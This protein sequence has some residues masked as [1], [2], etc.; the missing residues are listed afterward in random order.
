MFKTPL[1]AL[2][3]AVLIAGSLVVPTFAQTASGST[4]TTSSGSATQS[5]RRRPP[6]GL[7]SGGR[8]GGSNRARRP[9]APPD[10]AVVMAEAQAVLSTAGNSCT[11]SEAAFLGQDQQQQKVYEVV[12]AAGTGPGY[13]MIAKAAPTPPELIDCVL[14]AGQAQRA[15]AANPAAEVETCNLPG[16]QNPLAVI[17]GYAQGAGVACTID[18]GMA[19]GKSASGKDVYEVG[20]NGADGYWIERADDGAW[21]ATECTIIVSQ[22]ATCRFTTTEEIAASFKARLV[23]TA[24]DDC[25]VTQVRFM[26]ANTNG[27]FYEAK[28]SAENTGYIARTNPTGAVQQVYGCATAQRIGGGCTLTPVAAAPATQE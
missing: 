3:S 8:A 7:Q 13:I 12:C 11:P 15:R 6:P 27:R 19:V 10:P 28:C 26:G 18:Q 4:A 1:A 17:T 20:C 25:D 22:N 23:G 5:N 24:A 16:N 21:A 9:A 14:L 2:C